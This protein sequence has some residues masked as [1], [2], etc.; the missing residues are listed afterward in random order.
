MR[1]I[2]EAAVILVGTFGW[3]GFIY[4]ELSM[5]TEN[6]AQETE[7]EQQDAEA[8]TRETEADAGIKNADKST[9]Q[10][11]QPEMKKS[12]KEKAD[13]LAGIG[14]ELGNKG[15]V[16]GNLCIKSRIAEYLYQRKEKDKAEKESGYEQPKCTYRGV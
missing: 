5:M 14:E 15:I 8:E 12:R 9:S 2:Y 7:A 1:K 11:M 13:L 6:Y 16:S 10:T 4:P 3:W